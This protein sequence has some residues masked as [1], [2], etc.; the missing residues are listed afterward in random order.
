MEAQILSFLTSPLGDSGEL[1]VPN[2]LPQERTPEFFEHLSVSAP[3][4]V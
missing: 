2:V 1:Q 3:E 4:P